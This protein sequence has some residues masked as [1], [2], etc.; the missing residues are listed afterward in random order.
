M[1]GEHRPFLAGPPARAP[2][3]RTLAARY[4]PTLLERSHRRIRVRVTIAADGARDAPP[5]DPGARLAPA[6]GGV[7]AILAADPRTRGR[8]P[9]TTAARRAHSPRAARRSVATRTPG[10]AFPAAASQAT[11]PA[12]PRSRTIATHRARL[13]ALAARGPNLADDERSHR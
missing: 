2:L 13:S 5:A 11:E 6:A 10:V 9:R 7:R 12:R 4:D 8:S 1:P 3:P